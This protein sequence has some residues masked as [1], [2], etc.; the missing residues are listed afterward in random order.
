MSSTVCSKPHSLGSLPNERHFTWRPR[1]TVQVVM[2]VSCICRWSQRIALCCNWPRGNRYCHLTQAAS[3]SPHLRQCFGCS[4]LPLRGKQLFAIVTQLH[5][6]RKG[7]T[8]SWGCWNSG[9]ELSLYAIIE[10]ATASKAIIIAQSTQWWLTC[11]TCVIGE[12]QNLLWVRWRPIDLQLLGYCA[13]S[14]ANHLE[15][16]CSLSK[17][18]CFINNLNIY[19][20]KLQRRVIPQIVSTETF[21]RSFGKVDSRIRKTEETCICRI[22]YLC[23]K[24]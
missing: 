14:N 21:W 22:R 20:T 12:A 23:L 3:G 18:D 5:Y 6:M 13:A 17:T 4:Y 9:N 16:S 8:R 2:V 1:S 11:Q 7:A 10:S 15:P 24:V 19:I